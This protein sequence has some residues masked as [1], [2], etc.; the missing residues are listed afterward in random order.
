MKYCPYCGAELLSEDVVFCVECG[1]PM[2]ERSAC[3]PE[4]RRNDDKV[5]NAQDDVPAAPSETEAEQAPVLEQINPD[6]GYDGYYNDVIPDD[7]GNIRT[8]I[9][10]QLVKKVAVLAI[11]VILI[12][13]ACVAIMYI[14]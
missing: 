5:Q 6:E 7:H 9:D 14:L 4:N 11:S 13:C 2:P 10:K 1:K 8:G 3:E 12:I